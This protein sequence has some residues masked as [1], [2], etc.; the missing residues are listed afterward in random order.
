MG[1]CAVEPG[2]CL[3]LWGCLGVASQNVPP[4]EPLR[5]SFYHTCWCGSRARYFPREGSFVPL[6]PVLG[7]PSPPPGV[8]RSPWLLLPGDW[9][10]NST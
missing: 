6:G 2:G 5:E 9:A 7:Q 10:T 4:R 3:G 1:G 8:L